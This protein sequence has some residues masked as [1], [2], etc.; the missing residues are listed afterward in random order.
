M[1]ELPRDVEDDIAHFSKQLASLTFSVSGRELFQFEK[2]MPSLFCQFCHN[3]FFDQLPF[4]I[5]AELEE[6]EDREIDRA[7]EHIISHGK[8]E[9]TSPAQIQAEISS[10]QQSPSP[11]VLITSA[12]TVSPVTS[13]GTEDDL[14]RPLPTDPFDMDSSPMMDRIEAATT[15][16][17]HQIPG[18]SGGDSPQSSDE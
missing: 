4:T 1:P 14:D 3:K 9:K 8:E 11:A 10:E 16:Q 18:T 5:F 6:E 7:R 2:S 13:A 15:L 17:A 12:V